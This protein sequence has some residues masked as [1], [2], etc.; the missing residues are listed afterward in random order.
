VTL[1]GGAGADWTPT[2]AP[3]TSGLW[4]GT[5]GNVKVD[6]AGGSTGVTLN[7]VPVGE[8]HI[9]VTKVYNTTD[10][11]TASSIEALY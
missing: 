4:I 3:L 7:S 2:K 6:M 5:T 10:G 8:L 1:T 9:A 11:T